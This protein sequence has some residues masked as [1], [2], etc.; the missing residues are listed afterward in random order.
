MPYSL[1]RNNALWNLFPANK[2]VNNSKR[3]KLPEQRFLKSR[4]YRIRDYWDMCYE[5]E[6]LLF[7]KEIKSLTG[8]S[9]FNTN[10]SQDIFR[11]FCEQV[12]V[13]ALQNVQIH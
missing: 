6:P 3:D 4:E 2:K 5:T 9:Y 7:E 12:E 10:I 8:H 1:W 11:Q 13:L